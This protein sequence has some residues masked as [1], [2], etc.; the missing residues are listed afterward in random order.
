MMVKWTSK[1]GQRHGQ[2]KMVKWTS[3]DD[4]RQGEVRMGKS[5]MDKQRGAMKWTSKG[6]QMEE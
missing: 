3:K 5:N 6:G 4:Q 2:V 1:D